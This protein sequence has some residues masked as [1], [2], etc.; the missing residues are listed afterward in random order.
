[1][2]GSLVASET[3][4][5]TLVNLAD[6]KKI[7][8][9]VLKRMRDY[10]AG[11]HPS[12]FQGLGFDFVGLRDWQP[13]D[14]PSDIDWPQSTLT[15]FSPLVSREFEEDSAASMV[16][17]A[18]TSLSTR[19]GAGNMSIA[20]VVARSVA[21][22]GLAGAF[23]QNRVGL[24]TLNQHNR[25]LAVR[26]RAGKNH[27]IHCIETYQKEVFATE[28]NHAD[29]PA[30]LIGLMRHRSLV[31]VISDFLLPDASNMIQELGQLGTVHDVFLVLIDCTF[32]Y[33]LP[34]LSAGWVE[35]YDVE[36]QQTRLLSAREL[37][38][39][40]QEISEWQDAVIGLATD[41]GLEVVRVKP[42]NE[43]EELA[44]FLA[45]RRVRRR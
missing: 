34:T 36:T 43:H 6:L 4:S 18:D 12:V 23:L 24:V 15:N 22:L 29:T 10:A 1:M 31:P 28:H 26:P 42:D 37:D 27:A 35:T 44:N 19:F 41:T 30:S 33:K 25:R 9:I 2:T 17:V 20:K 32:V 14:R 8:L 21:T 39:L 16:I 5:S 40:A 3:R 38:R 11:T 45:Q 13:G 7:E